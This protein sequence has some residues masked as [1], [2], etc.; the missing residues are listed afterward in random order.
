MESECFTFNDM[1]TNANRIS[2]R[3]GISQTHIGSRKRAPCILLHFK[4]KILRY[5]CTINICFYFYRCRCSIF[6]ANFVYSVR[7]GSL[8]W[9]LGGSMNSV[10]M[11]RQ[12]LSISCTCWRRHRLSQHVLFAQIYR[13]RDTNAECEW[14]TQ[15]TQWRTKK[16][17]MR[18]KIMGT[19]LEL[20]QNSHFVNSANRRVLIPTQTWIEWSII[21][22]VVVNS[23]KWMVF[24]FAFQSILLSNNISTV[25]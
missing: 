14:L 16:N 15:W 19:F 2:F 5:I 25:Q 18:N 10:A 4:R 23:Q 24:T 22:V 1:Q 20:Y 13:H 21:V 9:L 6:V 7:H 12:R 11:A 17:L 8:C 3:P